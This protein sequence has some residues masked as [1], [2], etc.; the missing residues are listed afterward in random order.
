[1]TSNKKRNAYRKGIAKKA[2][3]EKL[4]LKQSKAKAAARLSNDAFEAQA[5]ATGKTEAQL[6]V[7]SW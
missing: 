3:N 4:W 1:M 2:K 5:K 6:I 7:E